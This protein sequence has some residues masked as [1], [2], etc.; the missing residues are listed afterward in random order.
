MSVQ[1]SALD[2]SHGEL[3]NG[4]QRVFEAHVRLS[5]TRTARIASPRIEAFLYVQRTRTRGFVRMQ[6]TVASVYRFVYN[7]SARLRMV[8]Q[9]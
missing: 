4:H 9:V 6:Q 8:V 1:E 5:A 7:K 3:G 2:F